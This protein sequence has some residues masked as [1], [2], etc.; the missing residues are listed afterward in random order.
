MRS[1][2]KGKRHVPTRDT[3]SVWDLGDAEGK[4]TLVNGARVRGRYRIKKQRPTEIA[5]IAG[6]LPRTW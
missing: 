4:K 2:T 3:A 6:T 5:I 1:E